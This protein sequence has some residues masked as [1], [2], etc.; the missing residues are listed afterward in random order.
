MA[1]V[2]KGEKPYINYFHHKNS[3][4]QW[5]GEKYHSNVIK[6]LCCDVIFLYYWFIPLLLVYNM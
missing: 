4:Q 6:I 2:I 5:A 1:I 3:R